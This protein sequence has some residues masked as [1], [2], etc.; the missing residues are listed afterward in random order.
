[1][2]FEPQSP[3]SHPKETKYSDFRL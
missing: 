1:M 2:T 3:A